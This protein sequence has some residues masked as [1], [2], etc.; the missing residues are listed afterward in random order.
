MGE[1]RRIYGQV[2]VDGA[3]MRCVSLDVEQTSTGSADKMHAVLALTAT[4]GLAFWA[5]LA[6]TKPEV[7]AAVVVSGGAAA[8][9]LLFEGEL[10]SIH[11]SADQTEVKISARDKSQR[12]IQSKGTRAH[13]NK[14]AR[15]IVGEIAGRHGLTPVFGSSVPASKAGK[16]YNLDW[17][18]LDDQHSDWTVI[19]HL[20]DREGMV[21]YVQKGKLHFEE[22]DAGTQGSFAVR[23]VPPTPASMAQSNNVAKLSFDINLEAGKSHK[24]GVHS[25]HSKTKKSIKGEAQVPAGTQAPSLYDSGKLGGGK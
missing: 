19:R 24:V 8:G 14:T 15:D 9:S 2:T 23:Y 4:P 17:A 5:D 1:V 25:H 3:V 6:G 11:I 16:I 20:A 12:P 21:A 10:D 7:T 22:L 18:K 13:K